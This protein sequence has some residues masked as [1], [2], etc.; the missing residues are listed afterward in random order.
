MSQNKK[1]ITIMYQACELQ[2]PQAMQMEQFVLGA[3]LRDNQVMSDVVDKLTEADFYKPGHQLVYQA[4]L[5]L[6]AEGKGTDIELVA[7]E[8]IRMNG[9]SRVGG[10]VGLVDLAESAVSVANLHSWISVIKEKSQR[11][12]MISACNQIIGQCHN[13]DS[14][15]E[16]LSAAE[17]SIFAVTNVSSGLNAQSIGNL[18]PDALHEVM[19]FQS[20]KAQA[21][22][23]YTGFENLDYLIQGMAPGNLIVLAGRPSFGK[24]QLGLQIGSNIISHTNKSILFVSLE[25]T[26]R[27][28]AFR[29]L[30]SE[31]NVE[32][33]S[34]RA[35]K[36]SSEETDRIARAQMRLQDKPLQ[37][38]AP[39]TLTIPELRGLA[40]RQKSENDTALMIVDYLTLIDAGRKHENNTIAVGYISRMLKAIAKEL[41]IPVIVISQLSRAPYQRADKRPQLSDL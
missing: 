1:G 20:G 16:I 32:K 3:I 41:D 15:P 37:I 27:E 26:A 17:Q 7:N 4:A 38:A 40:R 8:L 9:L 29:L 21:N 30:C 39:P 22:R 24:T 28:L 13:G 35:G 25:M 12:Q 23:L 18:L 5:R 33:H 10:R 11:R 36:L 14:T 2:P 19:D 31:A 34:V 6:Y